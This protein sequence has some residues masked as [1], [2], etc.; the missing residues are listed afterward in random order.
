MRSRPVARTLIALRAGAAR[1]GALARR[2]AA[3]R[4]AGAA[5]TLMERR[6]ADMLAEGGSIRFGYLQPRMHASPPALHDG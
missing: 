4:T 1:A 3:G 6:M 5:L 2:R